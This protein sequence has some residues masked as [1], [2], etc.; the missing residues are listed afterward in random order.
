YAAGGLS[1]VKRE[2]LISKKYRKKRPF[3]IRFASPDNNTIR[4][5]FFQQWSEFN[6]DLLETIFPGNREWIQ[7]P[8]QTD[9]GDY[10]LEVTSARLPDGSWLQVG[11]STESRLRVLAQFWKTFM[12]VAVF[13][14]LASLISGYFLSRK[15]LRPIRHLIQTVQSIEAGRMDVRVPQTQAQDELGEL[16]RLFNTMLS[17]IQALVEGMK[18]SL[19]NVAHEL[20]TPMTR[21]H[22][23]AEVALRS[24]EDAGT[25]RNALQDFAE[26]SNRLLKML[27]TF[28]D[29]SEAETGVMDLDCSE[30]EV[31]EMIYPVVEVYEYVAEDNGLCIQAEVE[32]GLWLMAD[33]NRMSQVVANLLD[34]AIKYTPAHSE[35]ITVKAWSDDQGVVLSVHDSGKGM[36]QAE[37]PRIWDRLYR[38]ADD[39]NDARKGLGLGLAQVKAIVQAH[40]G[41]VDVS[42]RPGAGSTF[43]VHLPR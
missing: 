24:G 40:N 33:F 1:Q 37:L 20:R 30:F 17:R 3:F 2:L 38:V 19:D 43:W 5:L 22:N 9:Q 13:L 39:H 7:I 11:M 12:N 28:M 23:I 34:N 29:I 27:N 31:K 6:L 41:W 10:S 42:S 35:P 15:A 8:A 14:I 32:D 25:Y 36:A 4:I 18:E 16:V 26:E 21:M